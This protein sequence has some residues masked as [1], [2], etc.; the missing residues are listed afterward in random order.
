MADVVYDSFLSE[1]A[2]G[3]IDLS[4]DTIKALLVT[5]LYVPDKDAHT[6]RSDITNEVTGTGYTAGGVTLA[7]KAVDDGR[8]T[9]DNPTWA[10]STITAR[11]AVLYKSHG[12]A[13]S[14]DELIG[15]VDLGGDMTSYQDEFTI[16]FSGGVIIAFA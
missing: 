8:F 4:A 2:T 13:S 10:T 11:A 16:R 6:K 15:Y 5:S 9:A 12:G 7:N 1:I 3:V 14:A